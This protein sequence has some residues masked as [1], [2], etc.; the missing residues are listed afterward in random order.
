[1]PGQA[2]QGRFT[3]HR[4]TARHWMHCGQARKGWE[5]KGV[6]LTFASCFSGIGGPDL[7][8]ER[9]GFEVIRH[10]EKDKFKT[11][12]L[13]YHWPGA[14]HFSDIAELRCLQQQIGRDNDKPRKQLRHDDGPIPRADVEWGSPP[15]QD[16]SIA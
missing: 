3:S 13:K 5:V 14:R 8:F 6:S 11:Q 10:C 1:M 4:R 2:V 12:V 16:L 9:A 7:G 15:C